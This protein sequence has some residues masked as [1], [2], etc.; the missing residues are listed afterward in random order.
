MRIK[1]NADEDNA[2][3]KAEISIKLRKILLLQN[4]VVTNYGQDLND[5]LNT[6][7]LKH[8]WEMFHSAIFVTRHGHPAGCN[9]TKN[10]LQGPKSKQ[11]H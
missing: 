2:D 4:I 6:I 8:F 11:K 3:R 9:K 10:D 5:Q 7:G 1:T